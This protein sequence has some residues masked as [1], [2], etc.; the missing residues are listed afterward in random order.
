MSDEYTL[1][2]ITDILLSRNDPGV[3]QLRSK[4]H[5]SFYVP[6]H[7]VA[8]MHRT[9]RY[10]G[11]FDP[12][13]KGSTPIKAVLAGKAEVVLKVLEHELRVDPNLRNK[14]ARLSVK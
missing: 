1:V 5:T 10:F 6:E 3:D 2:Q 12:M 7:K 14:L 9:N 13:L 11:E 8:W 4:F